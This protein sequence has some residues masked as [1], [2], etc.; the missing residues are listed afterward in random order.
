MKLPLLLALLP[1][2]TTASTSTQIPLASAS[3]PPSPW[4]T[5]LFRTTNATAPILNTTKLGQTAP[6]YIFIAPSTQTSGSP[7]IYTDDGDLV[8]LGP[9]G[10]TYAYQPQMLNGEPVLTFWQGHNVKGFGYGH[11]VILDSSY[12]EIHR[13]TLPGTENKRF[14]TATNETF[15]SYIDIH[16][17]A[18]TEDGTILI[19]AV[20]VTQSDLTPVGGKKDGWVQD[21]LVYEID[22][23]TNEILFSWSAVQGHLSLDYVEFPLGE[24]GANKSAPYEYPHLNSVAKYGDQYLVSSRYMCSIFLLDKDGEIVWLFHG[25]KGGSYTLPNNSTSKFCFQH[26]ARIKSH[27][28]QG[29]ANESII[30]SLHNNDS[31]EKTEVPQ[32]TTNLIFNLHPANESATLLSRTFDRQ[33]PVSAVSQGNYQSILSNGTASGHWLVGQGAIPKIEEFD[34]HGKLVM[35]SWF[36]GKIGNATTYD[37]SSYRAFRAPWGGKPKGAPGVVA[38]KSD[39]GQRLDVYVSWNG[40]TDVKGWRVL[41][42]SKKDMNVLK[43]MVKKTG[44]ETM[45][46]ISLDSDQSVDSI[47]VEAI[48]GGGDGARSKLVTV[49]SC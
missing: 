40:A 39:N 10:K 27:T 26:D 8:W 42:G 32:L 13:V 3:V 14:V 49:G 38:C 30:L 11:I 48:G 25:Q 17:S 16:E 21:G 34:Q 37:W 20:N 15:P 1:A 31:A 29:K 18:I 41:G 35:R 33:D 19:T 12:Q 43:A 7:A 36:G 45:I 4:P 24:K 47:I 23:A 22:I 2:L 6:G 9:E 44:F 46:A 5:H 28:N